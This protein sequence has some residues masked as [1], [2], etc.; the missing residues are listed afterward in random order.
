MVGFE[1]QHAKPKEQPRAELGASTGK[2]L[3]FKTLWNI[4][5]EFYFGLDFLRDPN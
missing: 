3:A 5:D 2:M 4:W 1:S